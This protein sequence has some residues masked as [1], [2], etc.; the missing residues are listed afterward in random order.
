MQGHET[1][2]GG[3]G[4]VL[5]LLDLKLHVELF[6]VVGHGEHGGGTGQGFDQAGL[7]VEVCLN[8]GPI[9]TDTRITFLSGN[10]EEL[11]YSDDLDTLGGQLLSAI[12]RG[13]AGDAT[14][15]PLV[16][17]LG[18]VEEDINH[19]GTLV[20]SG[21]KDGDGVLGHDENVL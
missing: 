5:P 18:V 13:V 8:Y 19:T 12:G 7:V 17:E 1:Y 9:S 2:L 16:A 20:S 10:F 21:A 15:G 11:A 4:D 6:P 3:I 14:N